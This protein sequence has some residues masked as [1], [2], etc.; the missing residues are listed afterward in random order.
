MFALYCPR[1]GHRVLLDLGRLSRMV[2]LGDGLILL[3]ARCY[4]GEPLTGITGH[5]ATLRPD[6]IAQ[7]PATLPMPSSAT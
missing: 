2:N 3:E 6:Q 1:H 5:A 7:R 4:D